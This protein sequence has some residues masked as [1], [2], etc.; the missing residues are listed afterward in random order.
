MSFENCNKTLRF[1]VQFS[2]PY[3]QGKKR[4]ITSEHKCD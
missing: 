4:N 3:L 2:F 1:K